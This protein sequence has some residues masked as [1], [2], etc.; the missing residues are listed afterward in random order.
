M[1]LFPQTDIYI[2]GHVII[3]L[4]QLIFKPLQSLSIVMPQGMDVEGDTSDVVSIYECLECG[5]IVEV[6]THPGRCGECGGVLHNRAK[7]LE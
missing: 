3:F 4:L 6:E 1:G 5:N 7:S 2:H